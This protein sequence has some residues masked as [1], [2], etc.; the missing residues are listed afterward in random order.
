MG[1][2][3]WQTTEGRYKSIMAVLMPCR[4]DRSGLGLA[5][6]TH[7]ADGRMQLI[8]VKQCSRLQYLRFLASIPVTGG[9]I[10]LLASRLLVSFQIA[11]EQ[12]VSIRGC[13]AHL[14]YTLNAALFVDNWLMAH[15]GMARLAAGVRATS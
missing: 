13:L 5:P 12:A 10:C 3:A 9:F 11:R 15:A 8:L 4:S 14:R 7:L 2:G 6:Y 1:S